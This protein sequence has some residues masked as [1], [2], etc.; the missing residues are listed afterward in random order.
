MMLRYFLINKAHFILLILQAIII[1]LTTKDK[2]PTSSLTA[3]PPVRRLG[4][5]IPA[6]PE[7]G[8]KRS[9]HSFPLQK[10]GCAFQLL[11]VP[12][13]FLQLVAPSFEL[14]SRAR[15]ERRRREVQKDP[16]Q[17]TPFLQLIITC[18]DRKPKCNDVPPTRSLGSQCSLPQ[19][20]RYHYRY[21]NL[22]W[23]WISM[24]R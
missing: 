2:N 10:E 5:G 13:R 3:A 11:R 7:R 9:A 12:N 14:Y 19:L 20:S 18:C 23:C 17:L 22:Y 15:L 6:A 24:G 4:K 1:I 16:P 21:H 8:E